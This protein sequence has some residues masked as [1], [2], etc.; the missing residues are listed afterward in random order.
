[1]VRVR[2][3]FLIGLVLLVLS[4]CD[5]SRP[6]ATDGTPEPPSVSLP[7]VVGLSFED[8]KA[9][10]NDPELHVRRRRSGLSSSGYETVTAQ[11]PKA[12]SSADAGRLVTVT[13]ARNECDPNYRGACLKPGSGDDD[14]GGGTGDGPNFVW[15]TVQVVG[16]DVY[17]LDGDSN[18]YGCQ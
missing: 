10:V 15:A 8:A 13:V 16:Y 12:G 9:A 14:C 1:M 2:G 6:R 18:G 3:F 4:A 11:T 7:D 17:D 5:P